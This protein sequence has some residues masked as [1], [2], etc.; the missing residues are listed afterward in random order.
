M[1]KITQTGQRLEFDKHIRAG[2]RIVIFLAGLIPLLAPYELLV[3]IRWESFF[4]LP[5]LFSLLISIGALAV[6]IGF[7]FALLAKREYLCFDAR[8]SAVIYG[9]NTVVHAHRK[10]VYRLDEI[11][12]LKLEVNN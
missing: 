1:D 4:N 11:S 12:E 7:F 6:S 3:K 5:F 10:S 2:I 9:W 8:K